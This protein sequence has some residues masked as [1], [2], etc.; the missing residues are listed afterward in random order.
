MRL[1]WLADA[2]RQAG[3][4]VVEYGAWPG[5]GRSLSRVDAVIVHDTVTTKQWSD[6]SVANLLRDGRSD[7]P[8]PLS[9]CGADRDGRMWLIAGGRANHNGYGRHGNTTVGFETFCAGGMAGREE[10]WNQRQ[11]DT[12]VVAA[13]VLLKRFG[14]PASK[15]LGH[16]E[17]DPKRKIDPY[18]VD[19]AAF[20][21]DVADQ[22]AG[23][24]GTGDEQMKRGDKGNHVKRLQWR[25]NQTLHGHHDPAEGGLTVDGVF[26]AETEAYV[27]HVQSQAGYPTTGRV[28]WWTYDWLSEVAHL[29]TT[30]H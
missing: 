12:N 23:D 11:Y 2:F 19:M 18:G 4:D 13:A 10:P 16:K 28:E 17:D 5:R 8:G 3:L 20:R 1:D 30:H 6:T 25:I 26:G 9:Q 22:L 29:K 24:P 15:A 21:S 27:K 14:L 7:V